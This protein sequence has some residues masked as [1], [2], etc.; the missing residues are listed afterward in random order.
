MIRLKRWECPNLLRRFFRQESG[1][2]MVFVGFGLLVLIAAAGSAIDLG[3]GQMLRS[4]LSEA[5]DAAGL[6]AG[7]VVN[8]E[9]ITAI[10]NE[11]FYANFPPGYMGSTV[12][13]LSATVNADKT[14]ISLSA[15]AKLDTSLMHLLGIA[16]MTVHAE[17]EI[18]R[19]NKGMELVLVMDNTGSMEANGKITAMKDAAKKL[20]NILYGS[21]TEL[22]N[23]WVSLVPYVTSVNIG[24]DKLTWVKDY[25]A[26][27]Y[28]A[29]YPVSA[30][31]WKGCVEAR[32]GGLDR[33]DDPP[34]AANP[35]TLWPIYLWNDHN[36]DN[37]WILN[38]GAISLNEAEGYSN[39]AGRGPNIGCGPE[40]TPFTSKKADIVAGIN[41]MEPWR[42]SGTMSNIGLVW[43]WRMLSPR[44][45]G[46]WAHEE[47]FLPLDYE[48]PLMEKV[49]IILTD[50]ENQFFDGSSADPPKS[51]YGPYK[52]IDDGVLGTTVQDNGRKIANSRTLEIC[53]AMKAQG[54]VIYTITF[55]LN[56]TTTAQN[57]ARQLFE[58]CAT[59]PDYYYNSPDNA[60]LDQVFTSIGDSLANLRISR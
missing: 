26:G 24:K 7:T 42:R 19:A 45:R 10:V 28:P 52:R 46:L 55:Q 18:T 25:S 49:V 9:D 32:S 5:L 59:T 43:G 37:N 20:I 30:T 48:E 57:E 15:T 16:D 8:S 40:V 23:F 13:G 44:W 2:V 27:R 50:G 51:D 53:N 31:K 41:E 21:N 14:I 39:E 33:T 22:E 56:A 58:N 12:T 60:T 11:Y 17:S 6:S 34:D 4:K 29:N 47:E 38:S 3:R 36:V 54:V 35:A 1:G